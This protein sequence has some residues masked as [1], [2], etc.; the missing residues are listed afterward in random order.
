MNPPWYWQP[1]APNTA[2]RQKGRERGWLGFRP[3][4]GT[5][6]GPVIS[7]EK[8]TV[9]YSWGTGAYKELYLCDSSEFGSQARPA[10]RGTPANTEG[11]TADGTSGDAVLTVTSVLANG[12][13]V[14]GRVWRG[15]GLPYGLL[16]VDHHARESAVIVLRGAVGKVVTR[17]NL[18]APEPPVNPFTRPTPLTLTNIGDCT[19]SGWSTRPVRVPQTMDG[20]K[21]WT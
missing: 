19:N 11:W 18:S 21:T 10:G 1:G 6:V 14:A 12:H 9:W 3:M 5:L 2:I 7:F 20:Y 16:D 4:C 8:E 15:D 13:R 17:L